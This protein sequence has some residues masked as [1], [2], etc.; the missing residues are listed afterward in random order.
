MHCSV[1]YKVTLGLNRHVRANA[2][3]VRADPMHGPAACSSLPLSLPP[4]PRSPPLLPP[5]LESAQTH[6]SVYADAPSSPQLVPPSLPPAL[7][8]SLPPSLLPSLPSAIRADA[9]FFFFNVCPTRM[10][11]NHF[12]EKSLNSPYRKIEQSQKYDKGELAVAP[13]YVSV[14]TN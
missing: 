9:N 1:P 3:C 5:P 13:D 7:P 6:S 11:V 12:Q 4:C 10:L 2:S 8:P 14:S